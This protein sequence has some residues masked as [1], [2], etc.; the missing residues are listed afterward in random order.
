MKLWTILL[1]F[2]VSSGLGQKARPDAARMNQV[3]LSFA[4]AKQ[5]MGSVL[6]ARG[7]EPLFDKSYGMANLEWNVP[8]T[9][10][11]KFRIGSLT[12]QF[13]AAAILLLEERG[14]LRTEDPV[15]KYLP[16]TPTAWDKLTVFNVLT[17][18]GGIPDFTS[19]PDYAQKSLTP[20]SAEQ[21]VAWFKE[22]P[23]EFEPG[24]KFSYSNSDYILLGYLIERLSGE[25]YEKFLQENIFTPLGM[26]DSGYDSNSAIIERRAAGYSP[27]PAG[28]VNAGYVNMT[29]PYGAGALYSTTH[30]L[31]KWEQ[32]LFGGRLLRPESLAK[33]TT[34]FKDN[35]GF[36]L[37]IQ[38]TGG[39]KNVWH[40]GGIQ[41]FSTSLA[42][43][44]DSKITVAVLANFNSSAPDE[45]L[46]K[47]AAV[48]HGQGVVLTSERKQITLPAGSLSAY[49]GSYDFG[50]VKAVV[51]IEDGHLLWQDEGLPKAEL[52]AESQTKFFLRII[53]AQIE[54][55]RDGSGLVTGLIL[56]LPQRDLKAE[57]K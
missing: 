51:T 32:G 11:T 20:M 30:D 44:P 45:M 28:L 22:K 38:T 29:V 6:V 2:L 35:Y 40:N 48:A 49:A 21:L 24:A 55:T 36:G 15:K 50:D 43:Y 10:T 17:H 46:F 54:F 19:F 57:R 18:T 7:D 52:F 39:F 4:N 37:V 25:T 34:P 9:S 1:A 56:H 47:L 12:K 23:L 53:D 13:T 3:A 16:D 26:K 8:N 31:V 5:F 27:G 42:Y 33:M 14:K 41:G